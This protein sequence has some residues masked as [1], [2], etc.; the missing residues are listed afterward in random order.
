M[1]VEWSANLLKQKTWW[2]L[3]DSNVSQHIKINASLQQNS[4]KT[5]L[6]ALAVFAPQVLMRMRHN[7]LGLQTHCK[8][9]DV[10]WL[11]R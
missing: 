5:R 2:P 1:T 10:I 9:G 11:S 4:F 3:W 8:Q 7:I 6:R